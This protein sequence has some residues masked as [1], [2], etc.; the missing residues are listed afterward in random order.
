MGIAETGVLGAFMAQDL[1]LFVLFFD[2]M[3]VPF[4]FLT[5]HLGRRRTARRGDDEARSS[6][7]SSAR[8]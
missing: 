7:R 3:L 8:C 5:R 4:L 6:T 1:A 2:L